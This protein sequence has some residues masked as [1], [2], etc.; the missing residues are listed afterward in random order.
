MSEP[1]IVKL[2]KQIQLLN[3]H[4]NEL[5]GQLEEQSIQYGEMN[6]KYNKLLTD[7][8]KLLKQNNLIQS[9]ENLQKLFENTLLEEKQQTFKYKD[10]YTELSEKIKLYG[11]LI[12]EK[13]SYIDKLLKE[14]NNL[15]KDLINCSKNNNSIDYFE[16]KKKEKEM[17]NINNINDK[18]NLI[19][20]FNK[21]CDQME[22]ILRE[23]RILRQM[24]DVPENF[25]IDINKIKIGEK[26]KIEDYKTKIRLLIHDIDELET[27]RAK[28]KHNIYFLACSLQL[29]EP[30]FN[31][32][33]KEQKVDLAIYAQKIY[34]GKN[35]NEEN[36]K[37]YNE[38]KNLLN[39]KNNYI[40]KLEDELKARNSKERNRN[41]SLDMIRS[42]NNFNIKN[43]SRYGDYNNNINSNI[44]INQNNNN[45]ISNINNE[46]NNNDLKMNE[47]INL[48]KEQ[49]EEFKRA[50]INKRSANTGNIY[51]IFHINNNFILNQK[52]DSGYKNYI[53]NGNKII[54]RSTGK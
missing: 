14:N 17:E 25:G 9:K 45:I 23:N 41:Q 53:D 33:S 37:K 1:E 4:N 8:K 46:E 49:K 44:Q 16:L 31:L 22:D 35:N 18:K 48:L 15:K 36:D 11:N 20:D 39:E 7:Y 26:I 30:P 21:L 42:Y 27:E 32:L 19:N 3:M 54:R 47:I 24:A 12:K 38:L 40:K 51:N 52:N 29:E 5:K 28:L 50:L 2:R 43:N 13:D 6:S 34:E 10:S